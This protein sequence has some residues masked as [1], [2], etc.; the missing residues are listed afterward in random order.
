M[1]PD[2]DRHNHQQERD[3]ERNSPA[4]C[5]ESIVSQVGPGTNDHREGNHDAQRRGRLQPAGVVSPA[6]VRNVLGNVRDRA[7]VF[8]AQA[9][10]LD[11]S[12]AEQ[13]KGSGNANRGVGGYQAD[14]G[15]A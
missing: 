2:V 1:Q 14:G 10:P 12:Q 15:C 11:D 4:P 3:E 13:N 5:D 7:A 9:Q 6:L 8:P